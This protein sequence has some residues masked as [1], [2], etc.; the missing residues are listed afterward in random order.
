MTITC[1]SITLV[2][3][4]DDAYITIIDSSNSS[5]NLKKFQVPISGLT[6][7]EDEKKSAETLGM[8]VIGSDSSGIPICRFDA[9]IFSEN[10]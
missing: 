3:G 9:H 7:K 10:M 5:A 2:I 4:N 1:N 8:V 6:I